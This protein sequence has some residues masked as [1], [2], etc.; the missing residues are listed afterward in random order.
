MTHEGL[1]KQKKCKHDSGG[2]IDRRYFLGPVQDR[3]AALSA[4]LGL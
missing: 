3:G 1:A 2:G 4:D